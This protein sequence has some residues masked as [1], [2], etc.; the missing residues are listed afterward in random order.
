MKR[1]GN[2]HLTDR[3]AD[4]TDRASFAVRL[5]ALICALAVALAAL[6][7]CGDDTKK[8]GEDTFDPSAAVMTLGDKTVDAGTYR[9]LYATYKARYLARYSIAD[10]AAF[11]SEKREDGSTNADWMDSLVRDS[12]RMRL[13]A[14]YLFETDGLALADGAE[15]KIDEYI[16][17]L[18]NER[19][20]GDDGKFE[21]A[22]AAL[23]TDADGLRASLI[24]EEK[25]N[26]L[27]ER[28]FGKDGSRKVTDEE[29]DAYYRENYVRFM[30][31]NVN[32]A[33]AYVERDGHY[34]QNKDGSYETRALDAAE[35]AAKKAVIAEIDARLAAGDTVEALYADYSENV[36]YPRGYYFTA[37][38]ASGYDAQIVSA[39]FGLGEGE[40][41]K[42]R[43][44]HGMFYIERLA[45]D[46]GAFAAS[47][48]ADFFGDFESA[49]KSTLFDGVLRSYFGKITEDEKA[50]NALTVASVEAN[51]ELD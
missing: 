48:N 43:T 34:V 19:F 12:V 37:A 7:A 24:A 51:Y 8:G 47:E 5:A 14:E 29:R 38:T 39:A 46:D 11:W 41:A 31:I 32:D 30:Q 26:A 23:G 21:A 6:A 20:D 13:V 4:R 16:S 2:T 9:Y 44:A 28:Y 25:M 42:L 33:Y 22:L 10:S 27:Y 40:S 50:V 36:D 3:A 1:T 35:S 18:E 45:L 15:A 49:V 17:D